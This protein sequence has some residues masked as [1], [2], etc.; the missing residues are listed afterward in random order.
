MGIQFAPLFTW[1]GAGLEKM[2]NQFNAWANSAN[3]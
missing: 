1:V 3:G 2:A